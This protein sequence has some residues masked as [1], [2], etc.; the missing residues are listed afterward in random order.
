M[1][2]PFEEIASDMRKFF[3]EFSAYIEG[4]FIAP[5]TKGA[6]RELHAKGVSI[7]NELQ[8]R[9]TDVSTCNRLSAVE[10]RLLE[11]RGSID[12]LVRSD[13]EVHETLENVAKAEAIEAIEQAVQSGEVNPQAAKEL[14]EVIKES[15]AQS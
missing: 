6:L 10:D 1:S 7:A 9:A 3:D 2:K 4:A 8:S 11:L 13:T 15:N 14:A 12:A 5:R